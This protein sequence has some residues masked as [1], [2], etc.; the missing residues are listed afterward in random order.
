M[1]KPAALE[2]LSIAT[3]SGGDSVKHEFGSY[4]GQA[5][6]HGF[7]P[8]VPGHHVVCRHLLESGRSGLCRPDVL[9]LS[10]KVFC[11]LHGA[12]IS[13]HPGVP[14]WKA[15]AVLPLSDVFGG[16]RQLPAGEI[17][18]QRLQGVHPNHHQCGFHPPPHSMNS[19]AKQKLFSV[20]FK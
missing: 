11:G 9:V 4:F 7:I 15:C 5:Q 3:T 13:E 6:L 1:V 17:L 18:E 12:N 8:N 2:R 10:P 19:L 14:V 16:D 20:L